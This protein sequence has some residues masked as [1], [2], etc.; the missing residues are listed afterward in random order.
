LLG[1]H[2]YSD[3]LHIIDFG[4]AK[5]YRDPHT[6]IHT[7]YR[8]DQ[9]PIGTA[10]YASINAQ[11]GFELSRRDDLESLT[12]ILIYLLRGS[13]PWQDLSGPTKTKQAL[14][15]Q[16]K[17]TIA[18][19]VLC[20]GLPVEFELILNHA[21]RLKF[22]QRPNYRYLHRLVRRL[23]SKQESSTVDWG[24]TNRLE[25]NCPSK[26]EVTVQ[27]QDQ[28]YGYFYSVVFC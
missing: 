14:M 25:G 21:R 16:M 12:Y 27:S 17:K 22:E 3:T 2:S 13:L 26:G 6:H 15:L 20:E 7:K 1:C 23:L 18:P 28:R 10:R 11:S 9:S 4:L 24:V 5:Q 8:T 19:H